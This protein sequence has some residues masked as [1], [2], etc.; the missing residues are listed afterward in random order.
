MSNKLR[1][2][3]YDE[4]NYELLKEFAEGSKS[5]EELLINCYQ[6]KIVTHACCIGHDKNEETNRNPDPYILFVLSNE[7]YKLM[8]YVIDKLLSN[9]LLANIIKF[10]IESD[11]GPIRLN[12]RINSNQE[13][14]RE[15]FFSM[16]NKL[17]TNYLSN[18]NNKDNKYSHIFEVFYKMKSNNI[19]DSLEI[20]NNKIIG[21]VSVECVYNFLT[22]EIVKAD[23][24]VDYKHCFPIYKSVTKYD[25]NSQYI[26][27]CINIVLSNSNEKLEESLSLFQVITNSNLQSTEEK[28]NKVL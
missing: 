10:N 22:N 16:I 1:C 8:K 7:N 9:E 12:I 23:S 6:N 25:I 13:Q 2:Y 27:N 18:I 26:S 3:K 15:Y 28:T 14:I 20:T 21:Q 5:L 11:Y 24:I 17:I 19:I 4:L